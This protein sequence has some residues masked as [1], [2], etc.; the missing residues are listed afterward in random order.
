ML[1]TLSGSAED[2]WKGFDSRRMDISKDT[3]SK[4]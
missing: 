4:K 2:E 3:L 1:K